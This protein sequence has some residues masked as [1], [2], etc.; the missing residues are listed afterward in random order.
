MS[1]TDWELEE[2]G[3]LG[4]PYEG[5]PSMYPRS[6]ENRGQ[7]DDNNKGG[8]SRNDSIA[9][10]RTLNTTGNEQSPR[11]N[12]DVNYEVGPYPAFEEESEGMDENDN[13]T[14]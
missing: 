11:Q 1:I 5:M 13:G 4:E 8:A 7:S 10:D 9:N 12:R 14:A 2:G 6:D 3:T